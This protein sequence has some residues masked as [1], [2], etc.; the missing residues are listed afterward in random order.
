GQKLMLVNVQSNNSWATPPA[1]HR[2]LKITLPNED[3][4]AFDFPGA[5]YGWYG[6]AVVPWAMFEKERLASVLED[7]EFGWTLKDSLDAFDAGSEDKEISMVLVS[8]QK[9]FIDGIATWQQQNSS[10]QELV[11]CSE[12]DYRNKEKRLLHFMEKCM[13]KDVASM[14]KRLEM[15]MRKHWIDMPEMRE[16]AQRYARQK[17]GVELDLATIQQLIDLGSQ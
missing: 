16:Y 8:L 10:F 12:E 6:P 3:S 5:Q 11:A 1:R 2:V 9:C 17:T 14:N 15:N 7:R 4:Y 13:S